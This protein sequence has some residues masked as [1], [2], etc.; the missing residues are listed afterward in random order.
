MWLQIGFVLITILTATNTAAVQAKV[1]L[2][3]YKG[4]GEL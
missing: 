4:E 1:A 2:T 3:G